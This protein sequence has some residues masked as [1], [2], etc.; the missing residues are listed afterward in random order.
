MALVGSVR[1]FFNEDVWKTPLKSL[2]PVKA[3]AYRQV[4]IWLITFSEY[5]KD[6]CAEKA[7]ALT[8]FSI[9]S[10]VPVIALAFGIATAFGLEDFFKSEL[11]T[12]FA[13]QQEVLEYMLK[14]SESMLSNTSGGVISG[15]S[16]LFLIFT[17][18][19]LFNNIETSFNSIWNARQGRSFQR[20]VSDYM[21][22]IFLGPIILIVSSATT[23]YITTQIGSLAEDMA[24]LG[25]F[26]ST[27]LFLIQ[28]IPYSLIWLLLFLVYMVFPNTRVRPWPALIAGILAGSLYQGLQ[29]SYIN[30]QIVVS[31]Y[32]TVYGSF[33]ALPLFLIWLQLSWLITLFGAEYAYAVQNVNA[34]TY[35][36]RVLQVSGLMK[37]K[38]SLMVVHFIAKRFKETDQPTLFRE[39][40]T[41]LLLPHWLLKMSCQDLC[42]AGILVMVKNA[43]EQD[44]YMPGIVL[45]K[46]TIATVIGR[47]ES[48]GEMEP[49]QVANHE[50]YKAI[51]KSFRD[52]SELMEKSEANRLVHEI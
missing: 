1:K 26:R 12:Y 31:S 18:A 42:E 15:I 34:W 5:E 3:F 25:N 45:S 28:L 14:F 21:S 8:Y 49:P 29:W 17:V 47:L 4:R 51:D 30:F 6:K 40:A 44:C 52:F 2:H 10:I 20:K 9:L 39:L 33:A 48:L 27:I 24:F 16:A 19:K 23:V 32:S 22:V 36:K 50:T 7:S 38:V 46:L 35:E 43:E 41:Q 37:K 13:G 11:E